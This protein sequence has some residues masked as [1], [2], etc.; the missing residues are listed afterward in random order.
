M[1][2]GNLHS[3]EEERKVSRNLQLC[4]MIPQAILSLL[5]MPSPRQSCLWLYHLY[6]DSFQCMS[7][8]QN[9]S[10]EIHGGILTALLTSQLEVSPTSQSHHVQKC[11]W[12]WPSPNL[13]I[14]WH[15]QHTKCYHHPPST[16]VQAPSS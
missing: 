7:L 5:S 6:V 13:L 15:S 11:A 14:L 8:P 16:V 1:P 3:G 9:T 12:N 4:L 2:S 10:S